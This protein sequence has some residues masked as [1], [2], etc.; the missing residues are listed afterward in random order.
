M[1]VLFSSG[2]A[3]LLALAAGSARADG[4][5]YQ[6]PKDGTWARYD[7]EIDGRVEMEIGGKIDQPELK[8][9]GSLRMASVGRTIEKG[10]P[11]R[12]IEVKLHAKMRIGDGKE[13]VDR[14]T[15][16]VLIPERYLKKGESP[17]DHVV[18]GWCRIDDREPGKLEDPKNVDESPL[19]ILLAAPLK[20][21]E[22]LEEVVVES[23]LGKLSCAGRAG[24]MEFRMRGNC[25]LH[26]K[27]ENRLHPKAPFGVVSS[28]WIMH[29]ISDG[30]P[31]VRTTWNLRLGDSGQSAKS[32]LPE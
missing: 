9:G 18:R 24:R 1:R 4:L 13:Y 32:E 15:A 8:G 28:R 14:R 19:A 26:I 25:T 10:E 30:G 6:L 7:M 11:C 16:K 29:G 3:V 5:F 20:D 31:E 17:L 27:L 23:K 2:L 21:V 22:E 12:W